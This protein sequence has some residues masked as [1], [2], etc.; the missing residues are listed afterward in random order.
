V[1]DGVQDPVTEDWKTKATAVHTQFIEH[2]VSQEQ[3]VI[4][5]LFYRGVHYCHGT[6][7]FGV[8]VQLGLSI[9][10][11]F[12]VKNSEPHNWQR[13]HSNVVHLVDNFF[14]KWLT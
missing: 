1:P 5:S 10:M 13:S 9:L 11:V 14:V 2:W 7:V 8:I 12:E 4:A 3:L 6:N